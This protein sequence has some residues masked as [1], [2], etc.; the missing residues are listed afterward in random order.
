MISK[1][2]GKSRKMPWTAGLK[3]YLHFYRIE[4]IFDSLAH[5][6]WCLRCDRCHVKLFIITF[7]ILLQWCN[8]PRGFIFTMFVMF[9]RYA[10]KKKKISLQ[11]VSPKKRCFHLWRPLILKIIFLDILIEIFLSVS[12]EHWSSCSDFCNYDD[13]NYLRHFVL[14]SP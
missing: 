2:F 6:K 5:H 10:K 11:N 3:V 9:S 8:F 13:K 1:S 12:S 7:R 14:P 4:R